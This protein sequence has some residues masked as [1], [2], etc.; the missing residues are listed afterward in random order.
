[1]IE[2]DFPISVKIEIENALDTKLTCIEKQEIG[3]SRHIY[4]TSNETD[5][6][7]VRVASKFVTKSLSKR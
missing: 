5:K 4:L 6:W 3:I 7:I 2:P 1:M